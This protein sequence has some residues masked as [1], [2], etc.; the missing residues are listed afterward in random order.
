VAKSSLRLGDKRLGD[1]RSQA[2]HRRGVQAARVQRH[3]GLLLETLEARTLLTSYTYPYGAMPD[4]TGEYMLG[5]V[6]VNVVL[7]ESDPT[8]APYDNNAPSDPVHPGIGAPVENWDAAGIAAVKA[9]IEAGLQFWKDTLT[10][11]FPNAPPNLLNFQVNY[12]YADSPI[13][14]GFEPIARISN[15]FTSWMYSFLNQVGFNQTGNFSSDIRAYNDYTRQQANTDWAF[16]MFVVNDAN[17]P[18]HLFALGGSFQLAFS[19]AGGRFMVVPSSRPPATFAHETGH[20]FWALD[21]YLDGGTYTSQRG[22]YNTQNLNA[23][24]NPK[25]GFVQADSIMANGPQMSN[26]YANRTSD[27]YTLA[28][29]G[30]KDSDQ[31]GIFDVL[32]VPFTLQGSGQYN[33]TSGLYTFTGSTNVNTLPNLNSS[34]TQD[35]ITI[36]QINVIQASIDGGAWQ[37]IKTY[38][39]RTYQTS[40][41][42]SLPVSS[43]GLHTIKLRSADLR[44]GVTSNEFV[45]ETDGPT[46]TSTGIGGLVFLDSNANGKWDSGESPLPDYGIQVLDQQDQP[47][48]L[49]HTI[50]PSDPDFTTG[51]IL[52]IVDPG[53]TLSAVGGG[54]GSGDVYV[55]SASSVAPAAGRV[56]GADAFGGGATLLWNDSYQLRVDFTSPASTVSLRAYGSSAASSSFGRLEAYNSSN[57]LIAR[58]TTGALTSA[59]YTTMTVSRTAGDIDHVIAYGHLG[60]NVVLDTLQWG[61]ASSATSNTNGLYSIAYLPDGTY[62]VAV[63]PPVGYY[64]STPP[65]GVASIAV[66]GGQAPSNV[67]FGITTTVIHRFYNLPNPLNVNN[68][69]QSSIDPIDALMVI[70]YINAHAGGEGEIASTDS[71]LAVGFVDVNNDGLCVAADALAVIN[72]INA[73]PAGGSGEGEAAM[74]PAVAG[75]SDGGVGEGEGQVQVPRNAAEYYAQQPIHFLQIRGTD[76]PCTCAQ[77]VAARADAAVEALHSSPVATAASSPTENTGLLGLLASSG[78]GA[79]LTKLTHSTS[80]VLADSRSTGFTP[81]RTGWSFLA[82]KPDSES[83]SESSSELEESLDDIAADVSL[84]DGAE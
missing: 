49:Q 30:W 31:D 1:K 18:D 52:N 25:P 40:V 71:P 35:D 51:Q 39:S 45:G 76:Q 26:A 16:T 37:T 7:M 9:N 32:D 41:S 55:R 6:A 73:H 27:P 50:E 81:H 74:A 54:V 19:F 56:F 82:R 43:S 68:N 14:T 42:V 80:P 28:T 12:T 57:K 84:A 72:Y 67:N 65:G 22:Y 33:A 44:T 59:G 60:T 66:S 53:A 77:C 3:R 47:L 17:D 38:P 23:A 79:K 21:E 15:N 29:I 58:F 75:G 62:H 36:N 64:P 24:D 78:T 61:P 70:N 63:T 48:N 34:G 83:S 4:D 46:S 20:Q 10:N 2:R 69:S 13:H 11:T 5:N 8:L